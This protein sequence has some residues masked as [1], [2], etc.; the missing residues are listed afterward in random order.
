MSNKVYQKS[1]FT[2]VHVNT[3]PSPFPLTTLIWQHGSPSP[4]KVAVHLFG[5]WQFSLYTKRNAQGKSPPPPPSPPLFRALTPTLKIVSLCLSPPWC[6]FSSRSYLHVL[7]PVSVEM[8]RA[9]PHV[10][11]CVNEPHFAIWR[12]DAW[13]WRLSVL[14]FWLNLLWNSNVLCFYLCLKVLSPQLC[15]WPC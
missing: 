10:Q 15:G 14:V 9:I 2:K 8:S 7:V 13:K 6:T 5:V 4:L 11:E 1:S 12:L 3:T